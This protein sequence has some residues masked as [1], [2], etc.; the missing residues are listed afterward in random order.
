[1]RQGFEAGFAKPK[2]NVQKSARDY[3]REWEQRSTA[4]GT[5][6]SGSRMDPGTARW[7]VGTMGLPGEER[8]INVARK[9]RFEE[10]KN[11]TVA[12]VRA[13][14]VKKYGEPTEVGTDR[15]FAS[16]TWAYDPR[17]RLIGETSPLFRRCRAPASFEASFNFSPDCGFAIGATILALPTNADLV[18][19]LTVVSLDQASGYEA[20]EGTER[21]LAQ[22]DAQRRAKE[23]EAASRNATAPTL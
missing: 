21:G 20:I 18:D 7:Y 12:S 23:T 3:R 4:I 5:N 8:V 6:R 1:V 9:E 10:G 17:G 19:E 2:I 11:P 14:L 15:R 16:F 13:A 22:L